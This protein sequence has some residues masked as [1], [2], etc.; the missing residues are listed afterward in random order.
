MVLDSSPSRSV[1]PLLGRRVLTLVVVGAVL[2]LGVIG[3]LT[4]RSAARS[5][6]SLLRSQLELELA[7]TARDVE[8][9]WRQHRSDLLMLGEN[10][11]SRLCIVD[12][13]QRHVE[14]PPFVAAAF[15]RM[16]TFN[17]VVL[18]DRQDRV[19]WEVATEGPGGNGGALQRGSELR[20]MPVRLPVTDLTSGDTIAMIDAT[21]RVA[22]LIPSALVADT[23]GPLTSVVGRDGA[24]FIPAGADERLFRSERVEWS[25]HHWLTVRRSLADPPIDLVVAGALD[26]YVRPFERAATRG[27]LALLLAAIAI[28]VLVVVLS[29]RMTA[30]VARELAQRE[31]LAAVGEFATELAHEVR[32]PLTAIRLDL[33]RVEEA[34][35]EPATV[36]ATVPRVLQQIDRLDRAVTGALRVA[37]GGAAQRGSVRLRDVLEAARRGAEPE[38][39]RRGASVRV[40][41]PELIELDGD[42]GAL[43]QLFLNLLINAAHSLSTGGEA[44]VEAQH[45]NGSVDVIVADNGSGMTPQQ[46]A[47]ASQPYRSSKRDGTGLGLKIARRIVSSHGGQMQLVSDAGVGTTVRVTLPKARGPG[48]EARAD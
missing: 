14:R 8:Q 38:F 30:E 25:G 4:T 26:R 44:R 19:I 23:A 10:E 29:R 45:R 33:Q 18:R 31:A 32:N 48:P 12:S 43:E 17:R 9:R 34:A 1:A 16:T 5:G 27:A 22:A 24:W 40:D 13:S 37:R 7:A 6:R 11:Q 28:V 2:P 36:K 35:S 39:A 42:A 47:R 3:F 20:D 41:A 15:S 21:V 46:L